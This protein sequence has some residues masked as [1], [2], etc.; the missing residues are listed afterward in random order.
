MIIIIYIIYQTCE[1]VKLSKLYLKLHFLL[2]KTF[3]EVNI[4][5]LINELRIKL[6]CSILIFLRK[7]VLKGLF[8]YN[9]IM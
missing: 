9:L 7:G 2:K 4:F 6:Y 3:Q 5:I 8:S 1:F